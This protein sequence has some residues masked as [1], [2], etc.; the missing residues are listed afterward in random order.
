MKNII[1][2]VDFSRISLNGMDLALLLS[3][4]LE[5]RIQ[6][7]HIIKK[8]ENIY[9]SEEKIHNSRIRESFEAITE[10]YKKSNPGIKLD[11]IIKEGKVYEEVVNQANAFKDSLI[12]TS[13][14]GASGW[15]ELFIGSNAYKI[16][17]S[18]SR[19]VFTIRGNKVPG[20][21]KKI[22]LPLDITA[23]TREKVP[24]T[25]K[26]AAALEAEVFVVTVNMSNITDIQDK[27]NDYSLQ[28][29]GYLEKHKIKNSVSHVHGTNITDM[30]ID[31][32]LKEK[33][34][35]I[36]IMTEQEKSISNILLGSYAHQMINKSPVPVVLFP[37]RQVG[38]ITESFLTEGIKY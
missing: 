23:E 19:P 4:Y 7:V 26:L 24:F 31:Y 17:A 35:L 38:V 36:S 25:A 20:Q 21:I 28:V 9:H 29:S 37:S 16:V 1:V 11:Y 5:A 13:T 27:L 34:D 10:K 30:T 15:E 6:M 22:L 18:S 14:H 32:A 8:E 33:A 2:P 3:K 12:V